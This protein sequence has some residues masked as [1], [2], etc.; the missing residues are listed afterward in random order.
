M[1]RFLLPVLVA[2]LVAACTAE[3]E[4]RCLGGACGPDTI[5]D[6]VPTT[7][8][9]VGGGAGGAGGGGASCEGVPDTGEYPCE[10]YEVLKAKCFSCHTDPQLQGAPF[11]LLTYED[12]RAPYFAST[13]WERIGPNVETG[14][15]PLGG[16]LTAAEKQ[17]LLDWVAGC[18]RPAEAGMGCECLD[19][20]ACP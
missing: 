7:S 9:G 16:S 1:R 4:E 20:A 2:A 15:M 3:L 18:A 11:S 14:N 8:S 5:P 19:A 17:V 12:A 10:V 6:P 13:V